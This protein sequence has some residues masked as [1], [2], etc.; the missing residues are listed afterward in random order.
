MSNFSNQASWNNPPPS[1][2][3]PQ[4]PNN[5]S[6]NN[7]TT[8]TND[9]NTKNSNNN[10][11][12][13]RRADRNPALDTKLRQMALP[14]A[15]LV[16][17]TSGQVH[18]AFPTT[19]LNFWLLTDEQ[20]DEIAHFYH[21]RTPCQWTR[22][23][24]CPITWS[25]GLTIE[26]KRRKIGKFIGLRGV[27]FFCFSFSFSLF[28]SLY[29]RY[30]IFFFFTVVFS[31]REEIRVTGEGKMK[32]VVALLLLSAKKNMCTNRKSNHSAR[33]RCS[34]RHANK[35]KPRPGSSG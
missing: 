10:N 32:A 8:N 14:L 21:Q 1:P 24:P 12:S 16:Q 35:S 19:L 22:H 13:A 6:N 18:P 3:T 27:G 2:H 25:E 4:E 11:L 15:P 34:S 33:P 5:P 28:R 17:L 23:Y 30:V 26:E 20:L 7:T 9:A 29:F 31:L